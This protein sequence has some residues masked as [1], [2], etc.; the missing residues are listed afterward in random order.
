[1]AKGEFRNIFAN[2]PVV[3]VIDIDSPAAKDVEAKEVEAAPRDVTG[4]RPPLDTF[5]QLLMG[6]SSP[7]FWACVAYLIDHVA[8]FPKFGRPREHTVADWVLFLRLRDLAG[9]L[10][11]A[12]DVL[13]RVT[14]WREAREVAESLGWDHPEWKLSDEPPDRFQFDRFLKRYIGPGQIRDLRR[15][16]SS[17]AVSDARQLGQFPTSGGSR[18]TLTRDRVVYG[19]G[20]QFKT[21][22][23]P[24]R[25]RVNPDTGEVTYSR[26]DPEAIAHHHHL[27]VEDPYSGDVRC[28]M[29]DSNKQQAK[30]GGGS[31]GP[32]IYE[33]VTLLTRADERQGRI[34]LDIDLREE[35]ETDANVFTDMILD[36]KRHNPEL[37]EMPLVCTYDQRLNSTDFDR[38]QD[39]GNLV[40]RK[41]GQDPGDRTK[42]RARPNER[43]TLADGTKTTRDVHVARGTPTL[44]V[45]DGNAVEW[46]VEMKRQKIQI[47]KLKRSKCIYTD[48]KVADDPLAGGFAGATVRIRH[49]ST[50]EERKSGRRRSVYLRVCPESSPEHRKM[51]GPREDSESSNSTKKA[52]LYDDRVRSVGRVR[53]QLNLLAFQQ[54]ENDKAMYGHFLRTG[55][56][57]A[58]SKRFAY[59]PPRRAGPLLKPA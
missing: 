27:W 22:F 55:D 35:G 43:F 15:I 51:Y 34:I 49:N 25:K 16:I 6:L 33:M 58:R 46:L 36:L 28:K 18:P 30:T 3:R 4:E 14:N 52:S 57:D 50:K 1:M 45:Y 56:A 23:D 38:L 2:G 41:V 19:D 44:K 32:Q 40:V 9:G 42:I 39:D 31:D 54:N 17:H 13:V 8:T 20:S 37:T 47:N 48:W 26:H 53:N 5:E 7:L 21:M 24:R 12:D 29:C 11:R 59:M 10:R